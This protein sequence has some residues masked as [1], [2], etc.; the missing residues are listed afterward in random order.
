MKENNN[1]QKE[2][3]KEKLGREINTRF[4]IGFEEIGL[5]GESGGTRD[6]KT[7][8]RMWIFLKGE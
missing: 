3:M 5:T 4:T 7:G 2:M 6:L 1:C 8:G